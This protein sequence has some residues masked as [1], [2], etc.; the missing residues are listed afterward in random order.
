[1]SYNFKLPAAASMPKVKR[2][3]KPK[4]FCGMNPELTSIIPD[5][6]P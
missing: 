1:M 4:K 6:N 2:K 5:Y 3:Q